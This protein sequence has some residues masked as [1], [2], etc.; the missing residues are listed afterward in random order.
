[1]KTQV[2]GE[3]RQ[4]PCGH[5]QMHTPSAFL[6]ERTQLS[7]KEARVREPLPQE[8]LFPTEGARNCRQGLCEDSEVVLKLCN[9]P[10]TVLFLPG[11]LVLMSKKILN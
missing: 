1:M 2:A 10:C 6:E 11:V 8:P 9:S 4:R 3:Q 7:R 5:S